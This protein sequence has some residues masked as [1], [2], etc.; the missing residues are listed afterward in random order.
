MAEGLLPHKVK[1]LYVVGAPVMNHWVDISATID[2]KIEAL[3][4]HASQFVGR[5]D[6]V[7]KRVR[8]QRATVGQKYNVAY[9]EEF[10]FALN[11]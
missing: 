5:A 9:A 11:R 1:E 8:E 3:M 7:A 2:T 4:A 10:H 6:E